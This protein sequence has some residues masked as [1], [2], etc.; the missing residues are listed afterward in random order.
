[1]GKTF[2][3]SLLSRNSVQ[4][5]TP[6]NP[7]L[8]KNVEVDAASS[9]ADAQPTFQNSTPISSKSRLVQF[10]PSPETPV[11]DAPNGADAE[12][13]VVLNKSFEG[14]QEA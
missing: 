9:Q 14:S 10:L 5:S 11:D 6:K 2:R 13:D 1:M 4:R 12:D 8:S 7:S 3:I